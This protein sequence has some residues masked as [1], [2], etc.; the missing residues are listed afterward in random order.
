VFN[1]GNE[2]SILK[3]ASRVEEL[4][5]LARAEQLDGS[6]GIG[7]TRWATHGGVTDANAH[8]HRSSDG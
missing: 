3:K 2:P 5:R 8:P 1:G 4:S 6:V 7:H